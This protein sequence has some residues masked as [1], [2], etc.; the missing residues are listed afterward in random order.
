MTFLF[1]MKTKKR[2]WISTKHLGLMMKNQFKG[3]ETDH[4]KKSKMI[5]EDQSN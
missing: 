3:K 4:E 5:R 1:K 2:N